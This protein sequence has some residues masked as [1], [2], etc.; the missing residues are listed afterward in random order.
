MSAASDLERTACPFCSREDDVVLFAKDGFRIVRCRA[1]ALVYVNPRLTMRALTAL[2]DAQAISPTDYYVRTEREDARSFDARLRLIERHR[3]VGSLLDLGCGPGTFSQVAR[4]RGWRTRGL[5]LNAASVARCHALGLDVV[6]GAF[7]NPAFA[8]ATFDAVV[9]NDFL[10]HLTDPAGAVAVA[11]ELLAPEGV[12]FVTTPN[13][14]S[15]VARLTGRR[16]LHLKP[17][18]HIVYFDSGTIRALL[19]RAG[20]RV[21]YLRSVGRVR[22]LAVAVDKLA[23]IGRLPARLARLLMPRV[24]AERVSFVLNPG[25]EMAIVARR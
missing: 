6:C 25:D 17:N 1:C 9:M 15:T 18:E 2:Y 11:R 12:L 22:N 23:L 7:P 19:T 16:W 4:A 5:D 21:E 14:G 13:I 10:E 20:F 8:G 3:P 24:I